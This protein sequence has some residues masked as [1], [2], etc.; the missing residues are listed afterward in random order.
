MLYGASLV[1]QCLRIHLAMQG[2]PIRCLVWDDLT[3]HRITK[4][5]TTATE[6]C[7]PRAHAPQQEKPLQ[8][9]AHAPQLAS[10]PYSLQLE[11]AH[12]QQ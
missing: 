2:T 7:V 10:S 12:A 4:P 11:K 3:C 6:G 5:F 9:E 1:V 8:W